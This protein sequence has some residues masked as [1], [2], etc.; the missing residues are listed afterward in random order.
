LKY[1]WYNR[2]PSKPSKD[3]LLVKILHKKNFVKVLAIFWFYLYY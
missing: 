1:S 2:L 3:C